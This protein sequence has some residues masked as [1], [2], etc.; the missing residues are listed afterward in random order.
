MK[1]VSVDIETTGLNPEENDILQIAMVVEDTNNIVPLDKLPFINIFIDHKEIR[2][3]SK[4]FNLFQRNFKKWS[5][6]GDKLDQY[7]AMEALEDFLKKHFSVDTRITLA[8]KNAGSFD[9]QFLKQMEFF[10]YMDITFDHRVLDPAS[11]FV[12][13]SEDERLPSLPT[14][15]ERIGVEDV[16]SHDAYEDALQVIQ[17]LRTKYT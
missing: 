16:V 5:N 4:T 1:Y 14:C 17:V 12:D 2:V 9:L 10:E 8:G 7:D 13:F 6:A 11:L 3:N 15:L